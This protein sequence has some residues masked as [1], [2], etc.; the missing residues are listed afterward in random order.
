MKSNQILLQSRKLFEP[1][2][3]LHYGGAYFSKAFSTSRDTLKPS[4]LQVA[5][6]RKRGPAMYQ[7]SG[8][9]TPLGI[10]L[11]YRYTFGY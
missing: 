6:Q 10:S 3:K 1:M 2:K 9:L 5:F 4:I 7:T 11:F 8:R